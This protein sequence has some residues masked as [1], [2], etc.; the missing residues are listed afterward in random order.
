M[1]VTTLKEAP[2]DRERDGQCPGINCPVC[3]LK[4]KEGRCP[5]LKQEIKS[6]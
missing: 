2:Q 1:I 3:Y 6:S 5:F 4:P